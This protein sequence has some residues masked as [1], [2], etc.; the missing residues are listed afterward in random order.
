[1]SGIYIH[2]P[3]CKQ[4]CYYCDF[5]TSTQIKHKPEL[6]LALIQEIKL[7]K[8]WL[9]GENVQTIYFGG[10]T[11]SLLSADEINRILTVIFQ[12]FIVI[13]NPEIT[14]EAN[15]D[16]LSLE[17]ITEL[18]NTRINRLSIG[19]QSF[20]DSDLVLMNRRHT[21]QQAIDSVKNAQNCGFNNISTDLIYG[22][23]GSTANTWK[24]NLE[25][26]AQLKIQHLSA[27]HLTYEKGTVFEDRRKKQKLFPVS[28]EESISQF[29]QLMDWAA[30]HSFEHYEISN[31]ATNGCYSKHNTNYWKQEKYLGIGPAAHSY[32]INTRAWNPS[33]I[34]EYIKAIKNLEP[35]FET[36]TLTL[37]D[38]HNEF[39]I[40]SLRTQWGIN[41]KLFEI[42][43]G[44]EWK[45]LLMQ[46][47][48][49]FIENKKLSITNDCLVLTK[50]GIFVSD[51][52]LTELIIE[53]E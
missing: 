23:P 33:N 14:L 21:A 9:A 27:Y 7:R 46:N 5:F 43:F 40:T 11:P 36:E 42:Q 20:N 28:E 38:K 25:Q 31:F 1:M 24:S 4:R 49:P 6:V 3:F 22:L 12:N 13:Q 41:L 19:I 18:Q 16:D 26:M 44:K 50:K 48:K 51:A 53:S 8:D 47:S 39:L 10:G 17:Y 32:N 52:I 29:N 30:H 2:V 35:E 37:I 45:K 15:P 34:N